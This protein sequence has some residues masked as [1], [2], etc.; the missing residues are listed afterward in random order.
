[1][2][3]FMALRACGL[4]SSVARNVPDRIGMISDAGGTNGVPPVLEVDDDTPVGASVTTRD[5]EAWVEF[6]TC[7]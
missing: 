7:G 6:K 1:M 4:L 3:K 5:G 2:S